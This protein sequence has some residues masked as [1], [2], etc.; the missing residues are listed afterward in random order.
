[1]LWTDKYRPKTFK[2]IKGNGKGIKIIQEWINEWKN[3]NP[4]KPLLLTGP[5]G[6]GKTSTA[7]VAANEFEEYIE[8]NASDKRSYDI[9]MSTIGESSNTRSLF[10]KDN[11]FAC[12]YRRIKNF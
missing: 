12:T 3:G 9:L 1:M 5:A 11:K 2:D 6:I 4:Q 7:L 8:L 10:G